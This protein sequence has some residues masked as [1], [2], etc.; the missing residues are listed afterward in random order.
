MLP[1]Y[2]LKIADLYYISTSKVKKLVRNFFMSF[3]MITHKLKTSIKTK[4]YKPYLN[5]INCNG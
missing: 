3:I 5:S 1:V 4:K 2:Q